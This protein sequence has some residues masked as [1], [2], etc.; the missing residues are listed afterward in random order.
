MSLRTFNWALPNLPFNPTWCHSVMIFHQI[1]DLNMKVWYCF[2]IINQIN[3]EKQLNSSIIHHVNYGQTVLELH[4]SINGLIKR[5]QSNF[6]KKWG[7]RVNLVEYICPYFLSSHSIRDCRIHRSTSFWWKCDVFH[8]FEGQLWSN[9]QKYLMKKHH[10][11]TLS[12]LKVW[13][14]QRPI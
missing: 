6:D 7:D 11:L 3:D 4:V 1:I 12:E 14:W 10:I 2:L 8:Q 9:E 13:I 5:H